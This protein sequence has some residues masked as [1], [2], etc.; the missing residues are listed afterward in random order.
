MRGARYALIVAYNLA[1]MGAT[2]LVA[3]GLISW[4]SPLESSESGSE[5]P[6]EFHGAIGSEFQCETTEVRMGVAEGQPNSHYSLRDDEGKELLRVMYNRSGR[7]VVTW[8]EGFPV[9]AACSVMPGGAYEM[10]VRH[11]GSSYRLM[12]RPDATSGFTVSDSRFGVRDGL[13]VSPE[14]RLVHTPSVLD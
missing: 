4:N 5:P 9:R 7:V 6:R 11:G 3:A 10:S 8:G 1:W 2:V 13:G 14:G 12:V